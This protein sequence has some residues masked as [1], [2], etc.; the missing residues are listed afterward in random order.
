MIHPQII[1]SKKV[2]SAKL[3][4][5]QEDTILNADDT[6][7]IHTNI[8]KHPSVFIFPINEYYEVYF[9]KQYRYLIGKE[10]LEAVAGFVEPKETALNAAKRELKEEANMEAGQ[11]ELLKEMDLATSVLHDRVSIFMARSL[12]IPLKRFE[13]IEEEPIKV[14]KLPLFKAIEKVY[15][16]EINT[17]I[18]IIGI[19]LLDKLRKLKRI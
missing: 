14:V 7:K 11:W 4:D 1:S 9:V 15:T 2:F 19:L 17:P 3:F 13:M 18:T 12:E 10:T 8:Y 16:C 5:I 6:Q